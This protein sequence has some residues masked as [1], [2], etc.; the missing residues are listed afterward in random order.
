LFDVGSAI[1]ERADA[2]SSAHSR[3]MHRMHPSFVGCPGHAFG[4]LWTGRL[5][6]SF[7]KSSHRLE[8]PVLRRRPAMVVKVS[9]SD[10]L[11]STDAGQLG[12][13]LRK[14]GERLLHAALRGQQA[15]LSLLICSDQYI[16]H[17]NRTWRNKNAPTDVLS[18]P[19]D[20]QFVRF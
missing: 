11:T 17:L 20:D 12:E 5:Q 3:G 16:R 2:L 1:L 13:D 8:S 6:M 9:Y 4:Y 14:D 19:Q 18:F 15:E 7:S 10:D